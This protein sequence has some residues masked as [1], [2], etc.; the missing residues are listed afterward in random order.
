MNVVNLETQRQNREE[1]NSAAP[2]RDD[3]RNIM[4]AM[5]FGLEHSVHSKDVDHPELPGTLGRYMKHVADL[6][7][8]FYLS[9]IAKFTE[10]PTED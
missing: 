5:W 9:L 4:E 8:R 1:T 2:N 10:P 3:D 6:D 7:P